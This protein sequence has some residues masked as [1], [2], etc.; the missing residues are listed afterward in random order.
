MSNLINF[1]KSQNGDTLGNSGEPPDN[2]SMDARLATLEAIVPTLATKEEL[3]K[4]RGETR[5][6]FS[7]LRA[8]MEALRGETHK[9]TTEIIKWMV[10]MAIGISAAAITVGTFVLNNA[11][12]KSASNQAP[13][14]I[15]VPSSPPAAAP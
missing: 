3:V 10:G 12:P 15:N 11:A 14:I 8:E 6:G 1:R 5:E 4:L 2:G 9:G 13:I 7:G